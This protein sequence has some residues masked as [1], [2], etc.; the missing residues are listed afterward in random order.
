MQTVNTSQLTELFPVK[1]TYLYFN[2]ASD[3]PLPAPS[4]AAVVDALDECMNT[5]CMAVPKQI[6]V[7][8]DIRHELSLF[9]NVDNENIAFIRSTSEGVLLAVLAMDI[10]ADENYIVAEDAF[11]TTVKIMDSHCKGQMRTVRINDARPM[12]D[13]LERVIDAKTR[14]IVLDWVH[15]FTGKVID[16]RGITELARRKNIFTVIDGIQGAGALSID[17]GRSNIDFFLAGGQKWLL[18][19]QGSGFIHVSPTVWERVRR[20]SFG[21]LGYNW[22]D[23][24]DFTIRP[25]LREGA[26]VMEYGTRPYIAAV[27]FRETLRLLN[28]F[29]PDTIDAHTQALRTDFSRA[30]TDRGFKTARD[31]PN[32]KMAPIVSFQSP[33][34]DSRQLITRLREKNVVLS[35]RNGYIRAAFHLVNDR[36]EVKRFLELLEEI[37]S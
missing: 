3:G 11:P 24:S 15:F 17:L 23:F 6:A 16:I 7:Y 37:S 22:N 5:G 14:A 8:E 12:T 18:S 9:F 1:K 31:E 29:G 4:R 10:Q 34:I 13:Q 19:P 35:L 36:S 27:A 21:W 20:K 25:S 30:I 2:H 33:R 26:T 32:E 28:R